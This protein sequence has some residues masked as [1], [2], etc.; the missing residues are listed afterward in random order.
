MLIVGLFLGNQK[1]AH[2][3]LCKIYLQRIG[4]LQFTELLISI[5]SQML[6][7]MFLYFFALILFLFVVVAVGLFFLFMSHFKVGLN[8]SHS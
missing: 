7:F 8:W 4:Y 1:T 5:C 6:L 2:A 3:K